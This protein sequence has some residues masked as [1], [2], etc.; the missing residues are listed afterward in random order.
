MN[1]R[2]LIFVGGLNRHVPH[3][4]SANGRGIVTFGFDE[5]SGELEQLA[6]MTDVANP[7]YL[8]AVAPRS[9][10][11][12]TSEVFGET[13][14]AVSAYRVDV[15]TGALTLINRQPSRGSLT[16]Y[17][18][19]DRRGAAVFVANYAHET[20]GEA[21]G[22]HVA[23]FPVLLDGAL[24]PL[25]GEF[26]HT[27]SGPRLDRQSVPHAHC[28][29][30]SSDNRFAVVA[31]LGTDQI[32]TYRIDANTGRL[33]ACS[34][35]AL[36]MTAGAGPRH[37]VFHPNGVTAYVVNELDSTVSRL[38]YSPID[39][40]LRLVQTVDAVQGR[41]GAGQPAD[42]QIASDGRFL[43]ASIR[44]EDAIGIYTLDE[45]SGEIT[46]SVVRGAGGKTP[47]SF[48]LSPTGRFMLVALQDSDKLAV[49]RLDTTTGEPVEQVG[50]VTVGTPMCVKA[51][52]F[53]DLPRASA[54]GP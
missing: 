41:P 3:F 20:A 19:V 40:S 46:S 47:R 43:Y 1:T 11:F 22:Q 21:P 6:E 10:L 54:T 48:A 8:A 28:V 42:L 9:L 14:G 24:G 7:T 45:P 23:S 26:A 52:L 18:N 13:E 35:P 29:V 2:T 44:G 15:G 32:V 4:A 25:S 33:A 39:G 53:G 30:P 51:V 16:A 5:V 37:V 27:G 34:T 17:C 36:R 50:A 49:F 38:A 12:A 31:D